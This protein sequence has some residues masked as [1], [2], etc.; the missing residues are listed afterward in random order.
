MPIH[1]SEMIYCRQVAGK[2]RGVF[3][4]VAIPAGT[5]IEVCPVIVVPTEEIVDTTLGNFAFTWS[6]NAVAI[7][8]G[9]G[10]LYNH[11]YHANA[12]YVDRG[13]RQKQIIAERDILPHE[14]ITINYNGE[15]DDPA[16]VGFPVVE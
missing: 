10:S 14:E 4:S 2:G 3:A 5:I 15:P 11:S 16:D 1:P 9:F 8:L 7:A 13:R 12:R 6:R